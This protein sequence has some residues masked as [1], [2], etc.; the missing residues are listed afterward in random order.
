MNYFMLCVCVCVRACALCFVCVCYIR[1]GRN[2]DEV[3]F[4]SSPVFL[5]PKVC[6]KRKRVVAEAQ[7]GRPKLR[8]NR[9]N[10]E[11]RKAKPIKKTKTKK[12][13]ARGVEV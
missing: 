7:V 1:D 9:K 5:A 13:V 11:I 10:T 12:K 6:K 4:V 3:C 2:N 8:K